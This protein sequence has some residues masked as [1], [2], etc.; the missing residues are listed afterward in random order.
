MHAWNEAAKSYWRK[1]PG[2]TV[3]VVVNFVPKAA[4]VVVLLI[5]NGV[6]IALIAATDGVIPWIV[7]LSGILW[8]N[9]QAIHWLRTRPVSSVSGLLNDVRYRLGSWLMPKHASQP[10]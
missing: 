10:V 2:D 5:A 6:V 1:L 3:S 8:L 4:T 9:Y 7:T